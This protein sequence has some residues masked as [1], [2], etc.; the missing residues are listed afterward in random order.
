MLNGYLT[1]L[2]GIGFLVVGIYQII[3]GDTQKGVESII[4]GFAIIGGRRAIGKVGG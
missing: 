3:T 1:Y 2:A 4:A